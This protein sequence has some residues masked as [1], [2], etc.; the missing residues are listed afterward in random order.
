MN[1]EQLSEKI[2]S[3]F[4]WER[5]PV[6]VVCD[7]G[8]RALSGAMLGPDPE[9]VLLSFEEFA[10]RSD[11][12]DSGNG[13]P[14]IVLAEPDTYSRSRLHR[15]MDF[16][17]GEP[18][19]KGT[20]SKVLIFPR[21]SLER[22]FSGDLAEALDRKRKLLSDLK[23][24]GKYRITSPGGTDLRFT[25]RRWIPLDFEVCTAPEEGS[26]DGE[27]A[28]DGALF[29][30]KISETL[31]FTIRSGK[32][33]NIEG[34][35]GSGE[36]VAAEYRSMARDTMRQAVNRQLAEIGIGFMP[37]AE[38]S[39]CFMEAETAADTCHFCFGS[40]TCY[41]GNNTSDFH[42]NSILIREPLFMTEE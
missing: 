11:T 18:E 34:L 35:T 10:E 31:L 15:Y 19:L 13:R 23:A 40:N 3:F 14:V 21:E 41:G 29:Y 12:S 27:I 25:A 5:G 20:P 4:G 30:R 32:V 24:G 28:V 9:S 37:G 17:K 16:S 38:I 7:E 8:F 33:V 2:L 36:L 26:I 22:M 1:T 39:D 42:G 6:T